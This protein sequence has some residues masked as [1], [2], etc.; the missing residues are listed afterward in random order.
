MVR[1][2][3]ETATSGR[4][5]VRPWLGIKGQIVTSEIAESLGLKRP[6]GVLIN[7]IHPSSPVASEDLHVRDVIISVDGFEVFDPQ[8]LNYR[9][10]TKGIGDEVTLAYV[11][12]GRVAKMKIRLT[13]PPEN[14]ARDL[15]TL[16]GRHPLSGATI[17]N[18]SP[19]FAEEMGFDW[20]QE[21]V[22]IVET[23]TRSAANRYGFQAGD[24]VLSVNGRDIGSVDAL[25]QQLSRLR[26]SWALIVRR[27]G[28]TL[29]LTI[30]G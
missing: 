6:A 29:N 26:Q 25:E 21:G 28:R 20:G 8:S 22:V 15:T 18:L 1:N 4:D 27:G 2:V 16:S 30:R 7:K 10:A 3:V 24:I 19:A 9:I 11:R 12:N 5:L 14:P 17:A 23:E 13:V